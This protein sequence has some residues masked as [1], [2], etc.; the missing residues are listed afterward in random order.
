MVTGPRIEV[1]YAVSREALCLDLDPQS[2][3]IEVKSGSLPPNA[4]VE[5]WY[6]NLGATANNG[7]W[8]QLVE[9][10]MY[11]NSFHI[12]R[13]LPP[14]LGV[15]FFPAYVTE[16]HYFQ[17]HF[18]TD[19][20]GVFDVAYYSMNQQLFAGIDADPGWQNYFNNGGELAAA[21]HPEILL[22]DGRCRVVP[23]NQLRVPI[24]QPWE[25]PTLGADHVVCAGNAPKGPLAVETERKG[26]TFEWESSAD[27]KTWTS[28]GPGGQTYPTGPLNATA[29][30]RARVQDTVCNQALTSNAVKIEVVNATK[31]GR[32]T[33]DRPA[34]CINQ[35]HPKL[36][37]TDHA[38]N[39]LKWQYSDDA[40]NT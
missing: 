40:G 3:K 27:E 18:L 25:S 21:Y 33:A 35:P 30:Y 31:G 10:S 17:T 13:A 2:I 14:D 1:D 20:T 39:V 4:T 34:I 38:G 19:S 22:E 12:Y 29:F 15:D 11:D 7:N 9:L 36:Q 5:S 8:Y 37:L 28:L 26:L 24:Y 16:N 6:T 32:V 23:V